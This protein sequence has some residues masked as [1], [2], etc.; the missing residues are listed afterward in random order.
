MISNFSI[1]AAVLRLRLR[2]LVIVAILVHYQLRR[3]IFRRNQR[4]G[5]KNR[6]SAPPPSRLEPRF[7]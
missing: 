3:A 5:R 4:L 2:V 7:N 1:S 6:D